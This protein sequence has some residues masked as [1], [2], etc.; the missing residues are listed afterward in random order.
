[1]YNTI[2]FARFNF[3]LPFIFENR[4]WIK[5]LNKVK[6]IKP[7]NKSLSMNINKEKELQPSLASA[8][9]R[10]FGFEM[11]LKSLLS[12]FENCVTR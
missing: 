7:D 1:M 11:G 12:L 9:R 8:I 10:A 6:R 2:K 5:E 3:K 4:E